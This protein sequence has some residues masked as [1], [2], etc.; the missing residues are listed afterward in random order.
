MVNLPK[1]DIEAIQQAGSSAVENAVSRRATPVPVVSDYLTSGTFSGVDIK[2]LVH[3]DGIKESI[4]PLMLEADV[5]QQGIEEKRKE[6]R[7]L[8]GLVG[9]ATRK[10]EYVK[11]SVFNK[12]IEQ[13]NQD[14]GVLQGK[15]DVIFKQAD[16]LSKLPVTRVLGELQT[17]SYSVYR[18]KS[19]VRTLGSVYPKSIVRGGRTIAGSMI[20]T[21]FHEH[22]LHEILNLDLSVLNTGAGD[23]D[24]NKDTTALPDQLPPLNIS[25]LFANE[26]G[27][28]SHMA[29]YGLEIVQEGATFSIQDIYTENV[30]Q[31]MARDMDPMHVGPRAKLDKQGVTPEWSTTASDLSSAILRKKGVRLR[32]NPFI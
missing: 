22:V 16:K 18:E 28:T 30:V 27:A 21:V 8:T 23:F 12:A 10:K 9:D 4:G 15:I 20:F 3:Y 25:L 26:Y 19:P 31:Y 17:F 2:V 29:F 5:Y 24:R 7:G 6:I 1:N 13:L 32:R 14:I 11:A